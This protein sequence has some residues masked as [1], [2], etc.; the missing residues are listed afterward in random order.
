MSARTLPE[1]VVTFVFTDIESSTRILQ[2]TGTE[3][4]SI[5]ETHRSVLRRAF[6]AFEGHEV[7]T[8]GDGSFAA[9]ASPAAAVL[10]AA[11]AQRDLAAD[12][13]LSRHGVKVRMG[14]NT[15]EAQRTGHDYVGLAVHHAAR[16]ASAGHGGQ[17]LVADATR[18]LAGEPPGVAF[19]DLGEHV[20]KD[21]PGAVRIFQLK[22]AGLER[23][24]PRI[25]SLNTAEAMLPSARTSFIGRAEELNAVLSALADPGLVTLTGAGGT[26]KTRLALEAAREIRGSMDGAWFVDLQSITESDQVLHATAAALGVV[27]AGQPGGVLDRVY[28]RVGSRACLIVLDNCE[29]VL[30]GA[31]SVVN[32]LLDRC[33][34]LRILAT[35]RD[36]LGVTDE[37]A[38]RVPPLDEASGVALF[39]DRASKLVSPFDPDDQERRQV[40]R[41]CGRLD[42]IPL[43]IE[44]A[45]A[46]VRHMPIADLAERIE[47]VFQVVVGSQGRDLQRHQTLQALVD[48]SYDLL[49]PDEQIAFRRLSVLAGSFTIRAAEAIVGA[50]PLE[51]PVADLVFRLIDRSLVEHDGAGRYR[52]LETLRAYGRT[53]LNESGELDLMRD[54]HL[55]FFVEVAEPIGARL[56]SGEFF[57]AVEQ[58]EPD[59]A[60]LWAALQWAERRPPEDDWALRLIAATAEYAPVTGRQGYLDLA[61][62]M[63]ET[64][65]TANR[66]L[67]IECHVAFAVAASTMGW[68][69]FRSHGGAA[70]ELLGSEGTE[71][72]PA[73]E[74]RAWTLASL[75]L[76]NVAVGGEAGVTRAHAQRAKLLA[77]R[78]DLPVVALA[79]DS[80]VGWELMRAGD[81]SGAREVLRAARETDERVKGSLWF[82]GALFWSGI[83]AMRAGD[84]SEALASY[85]EVLPLFRRVQYK[86]YA[87]WVLDHLSEAAVQLGDFPAARAYA[88][89]GVA[90][91]IDAG[92]VSEGNIAH[93]HA[94]LAALESLRGDHALAARYY[95][96]AIAVVISHEDLHDEA[97]MRANLAAELVQAGEP[98]RARPLIDLALDLTETLEPVTLPS[99]A[100]YPPPISNA[101]HAVARLALAAGRAEEAAELLGAVMALHP[102]ETS[103][104]ATRQRMFAFRSEIGAELSVD[105]LAAALARGS[106][107]AE[108]LA[109]AREISDSIATPAP[110]APAPG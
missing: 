32:Q 17:V 90:L 37:R 12:P 55:S 69:R 80:A 6:G 50:P 15:G 62:R 97:A 2:R 22:A 40:A 11:Q 8:D 54:R 70:L 13:L 72:D 60:N 42:G 34:E 78:C 85:Q 39:M 3:F 86:L 107:L 63:L 105:G 91:S 1:G 14:M 19:E 110:P 45:A 58:L 35:S 29:H 67:L 61:D 48:W 30:A 53:K 36:L 51:Q 73:D 64:R 16:V 33:A 49:S 44:L 4:A 23:R 46:R 88:Q 25:R 92:L 21:F 82:A 38:R 94:R 56:R 47:D 108:P 99:G 103:S 98:Q 41:I 83:A 27:D 57:D 109:R 68:H 9:F 102:L 74:H 81:V 66:E 100:T 93:L 84:W 77:A 28:D 5:L 89:E 71:A 76:S 96:D 59:A 87:Q 95:E 31:A 106:Q 43:A 79:A 18:R 101:V 10:A 20:L 65:G 24:F 104:P 7:N 52:Q 26:G 75:A